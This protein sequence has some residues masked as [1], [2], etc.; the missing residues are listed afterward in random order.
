MLAITLLAA[1]RDVDDA[2]N[3][4]PG[5]NITRPEP[6]G[7]P[8]NLALGF[9][10]MPAERTTDSYI[11]AIATAAQYGEIVLIQRA[12]PWEDFFPNRQISRETLE[13]TRLETALLEQYDHLSLVYAIDPTDPMVQ[14]SRLANLPEGV[15]QADGFLDENLR[16]AF[17]AYT[18]YIVRNYEPGY[19][20]LGVE[21]NML[22]DRAPD[23]FEAFV[24]LY[25]EAYENAKDAD[26]DVKIFPTFQL[27]DLEGNLGFVHPPAWEVFDIFSGMMDVLAISTYPYLTDL[28]AAADLRPQYYSQLRDRWDGEIIIVDAAYPS[29]PVDGYRVRGAED[30]QHDYLERLLEEAEASD[31]SAVIW[32]AARDP[33]FA[34]EGTLAAFRDIGL[35]HGDGAN[36]LAW[37][38]WESWAIR[39]YQPAPN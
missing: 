24:S 23:Q 15:S 5:P 2:E 17:V 27:E 4:T 7:E 10:A 37:Q 3:Y 26:P 6:A 21:V 20:A 13:T 1:C 31:F 16:K 30:D 38:L 11:A 19:L 36:K 22:R 34:R 12:P 35:R 32:R 9:S 28:R 39:P 25:Q 14:R 33:A 18:R 29:A 8:R